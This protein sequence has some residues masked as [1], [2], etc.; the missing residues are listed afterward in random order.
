MGTWLY[1]RILAGNNRMIAVLIILFFSI[2]STIR[3]EATE[4]SFSSLNPRLTNS[5]TLS[6]LAEPD[7]LCLGT[8]INI[9][10]RSS[11]FSQVTNMQLVF[12]YDITRIQFLESENYLS[13]ISDFSP[14]VSETMPGRIE[15]SYSGAEISIFNPAMVVELSFFA[16]EHGNTILQ[17]EE[18]GCFLI[19]A[20][21]TLFNLQLENKTAV[22]LPLPDIQIQGKTNYCQGEDVELNVRSSHFIPNV[23]WTLHFDTFN[24]GGLQLP[25]VLIEQEGFINVHVTD[26]FGCIAVVNFNLVVFD[27]DFR[28]AVPNAFR[29]DSEII[30][31]RLF[32]PIFE[33]VIPN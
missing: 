31:N 1:F 13:E 2:F 3:S 18:S 6:F 7:N 30:Q 22:I 29:P 17:W 27:C 16:I 19:H 33:D 11:P 14:Q 23:I 28:P 4:Q 20:D 12:T 24:G 26:I 21:G 15:I 8:T 10:V 5:P 25:N 9:S 32:K